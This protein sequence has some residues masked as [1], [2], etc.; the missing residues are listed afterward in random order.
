MVP[1]QI[2]AKAGVPRQM[3]DVQ[4][5]QIPAQDVTAALRTRIAELERR[6]LAASGKMVNS[7]IADKAIVERLHLIALAPASKTME[8]AAIKKGHHAPASAVCE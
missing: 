1:S 3:E 8:L 7:M 6:L 4:P 2:D 5:A